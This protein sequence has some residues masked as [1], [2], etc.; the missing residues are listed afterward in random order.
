[1]GRRKTKHPFNCRYCGKTFEIHPCRDRTGKFCS[2]DCYN[3]S[4]AKPVTDRLRYRVTDTGCWHWTGYTSPEGYGRVGVRSASQLAH[5]AHWVEVRGPI[6][7]GQVL[8]HICRNRACINLEHLRVVTVGQ[9]N[10]L[11]KV[12]RGVF[13]WRGIQ[14]APPKPK[15]EALL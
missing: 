15:Q 4:R 3:Y 7:D 2:R 14:D 11:G 5:R 9:N 6:T 10:H 8:D 12:M 1:M 13:A